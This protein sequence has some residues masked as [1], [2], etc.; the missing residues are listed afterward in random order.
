MNIL[1]NL[2]SK[3][4]VKSINYCKWQEIG[5][6]FYRN[7]LTKREKEIL[8]YV[9]LG[10]TAKKIGQLLNISF[11]TVEA[12]INNLKLKLHCD[13]K[14]DIVF[15]VMKSGLIHQLDII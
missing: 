1:P 2:Q 12:H 4:S 11:R 8:Q 13:S 5:K 10:C 3:H 9:V 6:D 14:S 15:I 7:Q